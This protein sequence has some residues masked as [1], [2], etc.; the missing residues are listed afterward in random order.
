MG[1][2]Q[3]K[4][5]D[6]GYTLPRSNRENPMDEKN[7]RGKIVSRV[8][9]TEFDKGGHPRCANQTRILPDAH[10]TA[11][12]QFPPVTEKPEQK[13]ELEKI[14]VKTA[15]GKLLMVQTRDRF[16]GS[17]VS[18]EKRNRKTEKKKQGS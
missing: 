5:S 18:V 8:S 17:N 2:P 4:N 9:A 14:I 1:G 12:K 6:K 16:T 3:G 7:S 10:A 11:S 15:R 13:K